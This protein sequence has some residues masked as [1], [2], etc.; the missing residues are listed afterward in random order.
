MWVWV[1][2]ILLEGVRWIW[3]LGCG[4]RTFEPSLYS[5]STVCSLPHTGPRPGRLEFG[6]FHVEALP[7]GERL[8]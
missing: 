8:D 7:L 2:V 1:G 5:E 6:G 3:D 4:R